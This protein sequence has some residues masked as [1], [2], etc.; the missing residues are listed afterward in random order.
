MRIYGARVCVCVCVRVIE[1]VPVPCVPR[2][3]CPGACERRERAW[4]RSDPIAGA[5]RTVSLH[6]SAGV[7]KAAE[8]EREGE[9]ERE[10]VQHHSAPFR[11]MP[12]KGGRGLALAGLHGARLPHPQHLLQAFPAQGLAAERAL[13]PPG[14]ISL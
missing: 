3:L 14:Q 7:A 5:P 12:F 10:R 2:E 8:R 1:T 4:N 13:A 9:R 11:G 6:V